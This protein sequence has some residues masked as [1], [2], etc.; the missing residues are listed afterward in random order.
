M[1]SVKNYDSF[2]GAIYL[3]ISFL[4]LRTDKN[5]KAEKSAIWQRC[6]FTSWASP[7]SRQ[8]HGSFLNLKGEKNGKTSHMQLAQ[9]LQKTKCKSND[10]SNAKCN[11]AYLKKLSAKSRGT[12]P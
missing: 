5:Y 2:Q 3:Q 9:Q 1:L 7:G 10:I 8:A 4:F 6:S 11:K 12:A